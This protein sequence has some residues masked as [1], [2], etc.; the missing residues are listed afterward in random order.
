MIITF[1]DGF[2]CHD[3]MHCTHDRGEL[4]RVLLLVIC[5][6]FDLTRLPLALV[7]RVVDHVWHPLA[8]VLGVAQLRSLPGP[9]ANVAARVLDER[10]LEVPVLL[11]VPVIRDRR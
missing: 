11:G 3:N 6:V 5:R 10:R 7:L 8:F 2:A 4:S 9:T 1:S